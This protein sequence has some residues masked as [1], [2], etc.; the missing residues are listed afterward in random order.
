M[1]ILVDAAIWPWKGR[2]WAHLISDQS[3]DE[4]HA[5][6]SELG[7]PRTGF[8]GDHY[9]I[10]ASYRQMAITRGATPVEG[11]ELVRRLRDAGLR[12][13]PAQRRQFPRE[14]DPGLGSQGRLGPVGEEET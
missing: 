6:A 5:F 14:V 11:R 3:Y 4:L 7:I 9:D 1:T 13:S 12:L 2:R 10:P 8:Q